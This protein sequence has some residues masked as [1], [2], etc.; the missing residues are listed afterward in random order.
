MKKFALSKVSIV[1]LFAVISLLLTLPLALLLSQQGQEIQ[2]NAATPTSKPIAI[3]PG[4]GF[5]A[6]Y[7]YNDTD[8]DG[9][10]EPE[11]KPFPGVIV[12]IKQ[13]Q[14]N[15]PSS[16]VTPI[17]ATLKTDASGYFKFRF[18]NTSLQTSVYVVKVVLPDGHKT[19]TTNPLIVTD[20]P[21]NNRKI[22]EFGL[23]PGV[24]ITPTPILSLS[25]QKRTTTNSSTSAGTK[26]L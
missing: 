15:A 3:S 19:N 7:L 14:K 13:I 16:D 22:I 1:G 20:L 25:P 18:A 12:Q 11:E 8:K 4:F 17:V 21:S 6:G 2:S 26:P 5:I 24:T 9:E 23:F 10:R